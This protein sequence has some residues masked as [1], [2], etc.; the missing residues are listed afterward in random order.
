[1]LSLQCLEGI[2]LIDGYLSNEDLRKSVEANEKVYF[3]SV[4]S[5]FSDHCGFR[6][7]ELHTVIGPKGGSK[8][9]F[10]KS[11]LFEQCCNGK[12]VGLYL[13]EEAPQNYVRDFNRILTDDEFGGRSILK[14]IKIFSEL[15]AS[16]DQKNDFWSN[17]DFWIVENGIE[18]L[19][20]DNFTTSYLSRQGI[21]K[22]AENI[23][24]LRMLAHEKKIPIISVHHT[25]KGTNVR[26]KIIDGDDTRGNATAVNMGGYN[27]VVTTIFDVDPPKT[28]VLV[29]KARYHS[30]SNKQY[31]EMTFNYK[32]N[33][34]TKC[35]KSSINNLKSIMQSI[36]KR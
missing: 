10:V 36:N 29:D 17:L 13:S 31:Y 33:L 3:H 26:N 20:F 18:I 5:I 15:T 22:E 32:S 28:F 24:K 27:Y 6:P 16:E 25:Q 1:M 8:S 35:F 2:K 7:C 34:F 23:T 4:Y 9:T 11:A 14:N 12:T 30:K 21:K 19:F